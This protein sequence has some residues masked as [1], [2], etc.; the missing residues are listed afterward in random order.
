MYANFLP[1]DVDF[2]S[3]LDLTDAHAKVKKAS[4]ERCARDLLS[5]SAKGQFSREGH[6]SLT[7]IGTAHCRLSP[8]S[9]LSCSVCT[10]RRII[11]ALTDSR[12]KGLNHAPHSK[13]SQAMHGCK[14][15]G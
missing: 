7:S 12:A 6:S 2:A 1:D 15:S 13:E 9:L 3:Y 11:P 10:S 8:Y 5:N 14:L 4:L